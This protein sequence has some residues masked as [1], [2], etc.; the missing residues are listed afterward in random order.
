MNAKEYLRQILKL[1]DM[2]ERRQEQADDIRHRMGGLSAIAYDKPVVQSSPSGDNVV[3]LMC[4]LYDATRDICAW[5]RD[6]HQTKDR[7]ISEI[8][9]LENRHYCKI[10]FK[11]YVQD[12]RFEEIACEMNYSYDRIIHMHGEALA[13]FQKIID[14]S[15]Q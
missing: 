3:N 6:Y 9:T 11:K 8:E 7:I 14:V 10:L 13:E 2:I 5:T 1:A 12:K 4:E 15:I